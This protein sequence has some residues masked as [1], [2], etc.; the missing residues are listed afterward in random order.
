VALAVTDRAKAPLTVAQKAVAWALAE[1]LTTD[2]S[3]SDELRAP[4][5]GYCEAFVEIAYGTRHQFASAATDFT[6]QKKAGR[7]HPDANPPDGALV[8]YGGNLDGHVALSVGDGQVVTTWGYIGQRFSVR[9]VNLHGFS[10]PYYGWAPAPA[11]WVG[12]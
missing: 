12:R 2:P 8:F 3:W 11:S 1:M 10:N 7:I 6:A 9:E 4:W 5:S